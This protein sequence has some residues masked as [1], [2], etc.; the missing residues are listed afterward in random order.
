MCMLQS[1]VK[2]VLEDHPDSHS[3]T[4][5]CKLWKIIHTRKKKK[6]SVN[7]TLASGTVTTLAFL[8][9]TIVPLVSWIM[10]AGV[11]CKCKWL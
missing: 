5:I 10:L 9:Y 4:N 6:N 8:S 7:L 1:G 11:L 3:S 2:E